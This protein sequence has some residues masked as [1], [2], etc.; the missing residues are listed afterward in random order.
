M[1]VMKLQEILRKDLEL[2]IQNKDNSTK[3]L[4]K[5]V[6]SEISRGKD[7]EVSDDEVVK[8]I[9]K[10]K[11]NAVLCNNIQEIP[12]LDRYLPKILDESDTVNIIKGIISKGEYTSIKDMGLVMGEIKRHPLGSQI[13]GKLASGI[14]RQILK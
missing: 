4:L 5:V 2:S 6:L 9:R 8:I 7:K 1:K 10:M 14:V 13:D 12:I 11:D 3:E